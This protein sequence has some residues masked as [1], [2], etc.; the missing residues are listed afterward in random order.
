MSTAERIERLRTLYLAV[1]VELNE[2]LAEA[3]PGWHQ[4]QQHRDSKP[5]W[6][7]VCGRGRDG[8]QYRDVV[9]DP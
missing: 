6:C 3:C 2:A 8:V 7:P 1:M 5:P 9:V 4:P